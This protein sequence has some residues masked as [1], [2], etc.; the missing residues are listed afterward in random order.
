MLDAQPSGG[1]PLKQLTMAADKIETRF[2]KAEQNPNFGKDLN[3]DLVSNVKGDSE[4]VSFEH[5]H[6]CQIYFFLEQHYTNK[7]YIIIIIFANKTN[8]L[9]FWNTVKN[10]K[11][12]DTANFS[13]EDASNLQTVVQQVAQMDDDINNP[14][15]ENKVKGEYT[16]IQN[17]LKEAGVARR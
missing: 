9:Q 11:Q 5:N 1:D 16:K 4:Q 10:L 14:K 15:R 17:E 2:E 6:L 13:Q 7:I 12:T 3:S 8:N